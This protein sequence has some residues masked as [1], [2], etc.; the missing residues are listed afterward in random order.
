MTNT[1]ISAG[2]FQEDLP[3]EPD[4]QR[5][6][7]SVHHVGGR[8]G[9]MSLPRL[10]KFE[11]DIVNVLYDADPD[12]IDHIWEKTSHLQSELHVLPY[13]LADRRKTAN[14]NM[15]YS[16]FGS[17]FL[18]PNPDCSSY[19]TVIGGHD[20]ILSDV[21]EVV[22]Q[23]PMA[24]VTLDEV[25]GT[26]GEHELQSPDFLSL[27]TQGSEYEVLCG[28]EEVLRSTV[29]ALIVEVE[30]QPIYEGQKLFGNLT[31]WLSDRG[32]HFTNFRPN[33]IG[34]FSTSRAPVGLRGEGLMMHADALYLRRLDSMPDDDS[35][36]Y[37]MLRKL[38]FFAIVFDQFEYAL[39]CLNQSNATN[40]SSETARA[41]SEL[42]YSRFLDELEEQRQRMPSHFLPT[43]R[44]LYP[45]R[46]ESD[47]RTESSK[48][49]PEKSSI[50]R[51]WRHI[52]YLFPLS[53]RIRRIWAKQAALSISIL[54]VFKQHSHVE[55][56]LIAYGLTAQAKLLRKNR[57]VQSRFVK[58]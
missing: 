28:G 50:R 30:F 33:S 18:T 57:L 44:E 21:L 5:Y 40:I 37:V 8:N 34:S 10:E 16:A 32:F 31:E 19:Y 17:S 1:H 29:L 4:K 56:I 47:A 25:C 26:T 45:T 55:N 14:F 3:M 42:S 35:Q 2:I 11:K 12:C 52:P 27:D 39:E 48:A 13:C 23:R 15:T 46:D 7:L 49:F 43:F 20:H 36:R 41:L 22:E 38:A 58:R 53:R 6:Y 9:S 54:S 24:M 51:V